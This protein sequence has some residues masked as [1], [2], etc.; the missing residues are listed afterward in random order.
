M[1]GPAASLSGA[2]F[3]AGT[4]SALIADIGG[5]TTD[6]AFLLDGAPR[7]KADGAYVGGWQ[8]MVEAAEIRTCGLGGD[9]EV[10]PIT[11]GRTGGVTL[12]PRR[13]CLLYTSPS[14]RDA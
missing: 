4:K 13:A 12:G 8:T 9:S 11:R 7:L 6:I 10:R 14:P 1:S 2:A 3:L 5:T